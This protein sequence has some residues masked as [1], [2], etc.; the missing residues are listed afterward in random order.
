MNCDF[1]YLF[2]IVKFVE[3]VKFLNY[4]IV[5]VKQM[6]NKYDTFSPWRETPWTGIRSL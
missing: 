1:P 4:P 3:K 2:V 5:F 6:Y